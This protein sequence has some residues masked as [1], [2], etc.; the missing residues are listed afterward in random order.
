MED[1]CLEIN[2]EI[3][4]DNLKKKEQEYLEQQKLEQQ[5]IIQEREALESKI[6]ADW[7]YQESL[8]LDYEKNQR[9]LEYEKICVIELNQMKKELANANLYYAEN[10]NINGSL[11]VAKI[12]AKLQAREL[13]CSV[14]YKDIGK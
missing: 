9:L 11:E 10:P 8:R 1:Q 3:G 7:A 6:V 4:M 12:T 5:K 13:I 14:D 2:S